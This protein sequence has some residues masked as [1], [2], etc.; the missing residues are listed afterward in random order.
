MTVDVLK[1]LTSED[2]RDIG[3]TKVGHRRRMLD[4]IAR[5]GAAAPDSPPVGE[6]RQVTVLFCDV[7]GSTEMASRTDPEEMRDT[8]S[9][10]LNMVSDQTARKRG[11][12]A[13]YM[14]DGALAY[15]GFPRA[16]EAKAEAAA[17]AALAIQ[18]AARALRWPDGS[19][20]GVR[21]G[22][23]TGNVVIGQM[24]GRGTALEMSVV[25]EA[26][27]LAARL[28]AEA[29]PGET[30]IDE[31]TRR[32]IGG[33]LDTEAMPPRPLKG[34][35]DSVTLW[36]L[37]GV[38]RP[39]SRF[40]VL[41]ADRMSAL[42]GRAD[43]VARI[44]AAVAATQRGTGRALILSGEPGIGKSRLLHELTVR[45]LDETARVVPLF[46]A[47]DGAATAF[48]PVTEWLRSRIETP[49]PATPE[50]WDANIRR[51]LVHPVSDEQ[52]ALVAQLLDVPVLDDR[53]KGFSPQRLRAMT[54]ELLS[55]LIDAEL[56]IRSLMIVIEDYHWV[57]PSTRELVE[58]L[59]ARV[60]TARLLVVLS[61][62]PEGVPDWPGAEHIEVGRLDDAEARAFAKVAVGAAA[63]PEDVV[64]QIVER[65][66]GIPLFLEEL[67][68]TALEMGFERLGSG[69]V[70]GLPDTI[71]DH[72]MVRLDRAGSERE[73]V[74]VA[75]LIGREFR[76]DLLIS[77]LG[78]P[79]D[80]VYGGLRQLLSNNLVARRET[81]AGPIYMFEH[82]LISDALAETML[83]SRRRLFHGRIAEAL[84]QGS[85][86]EA[87]VPERVAEHLAQA[88]RH[89]EA[90][91][92]FVTAAE[93]AMERFANLE[94]TEHLARARAAL[95][96][97]PEGSDRLRA[98]LRL[99]TLSGM[100][101][102]MTGGWTAPE[103][104]ENYSRA[105]E[106]WTEVGAEG[107]MYPIAVGLVGYYIM[108]GNFDEAIPLACE[109]VALAEQ[110]GED[111]IIMA[112]EFELGAAKLYSGDM[113]GGLPHLLRAVRLFDA[114]AHTAHVA[115]CGKNQGVAALL[116]MGFAE[117]MMGLPESASGR[118]RAAFEA[119][120]RNPHPFTE[121]WSQLG[122][123]SLQ[124]SRRNYDQL[125]EAVDGIIMRAEQQQFPHVVVQSK[126]Y[127]GWA[128]AMS[129]RHDDGIA[130]ASEGMEGWRT[131]GATRPVYTAYYAEALANAGR[132][133]AARAEIARAFEEQER[134]AEL[135]G[136]A[137]IHSIHGD[138]LRLTGAPAGEADA[139]YLRAIEVA[140]GDG[141]L[142]YELR[143]ALKLAQ[144]RRA[145]GGPAFVEA[146][147]ML[148]RAYSALTEGFDDPDQQA[149]RA[150]LDA[151][152]ATMAPARS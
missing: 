79:A 73:L 135:L 145:A 51:D 123:L 140:R 125:L 22:I 144:G 24:M 9:A 35:G 16:L 19:P 4:A 52:A 67:A 43:A 64:D 30:C 1:S 88:E 34:L 45:S 141:T 83:N 21:I 106:L 143:A 130:I 72:V 5:L 134:N 38:A 71:R 65:G 119:M 91:G 104:V 41:R 26:P 121:V 28:Q 6:R 115:Q 58:S 23:A 131:M 50:A 54:F 98:D 31:R 14:G 132:A 33:M 116:Q 148:A 80:A 114:D 49:A 46:C 11:L 146:R 96:R 101:H 10:F 78:Q 60:A 25:G 108:T 99:S 152:G 147:D 124:L 36:R 100:A 13:K 76:P 44:D 48:Y 17:R 112:A 137:E 39:R 37:T 70:V 93:K 82:A 151:T 87:A 102:T 92:A 89:L 53:L 74:Q 86:G 118:F 85:T 150:L 29:A 68:R 7:V 62:R 117:S 66:A 94:A 55:A 127:K 138:V 18:D 90:V 77:A 20:L 142:T 129:G 109:L 126:L 32:Q 149:A 3:V 69:E 97:A 59:V 12:V 47:P 122:F 107:E 111:E 113:E 110:T 56:E 42:V 8:L 136:A 15:F 133:N 84:Q 57:D 105:R 139:A 128:L 61:T 63:L 103:V 81:A 120:E 2:L 95:E 75:A 40:E 27:N